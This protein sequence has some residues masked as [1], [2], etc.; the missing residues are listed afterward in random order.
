[1]NN[2]GF[3]LSMR[4]QSRRERLLCA[5]ALDA[6]NRIAKQYPAILIVLVN[7]LSSI[8]KQPNCDSV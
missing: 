8:T 3:V 1:M 2:G 7:M 4:E 5:T 6:T